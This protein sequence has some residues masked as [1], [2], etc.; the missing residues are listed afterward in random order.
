MVPIRCKEHKTY[1]GHTK[2][3]FACF[4]CW[5]LYRLRQADKEGVLYKHIEVAD[6]EDS[7][8]RKQS[9]KNPKKT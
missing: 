8:D 4:G 7:G 1:G 5:F 2:P 6:K 3:R 9:K